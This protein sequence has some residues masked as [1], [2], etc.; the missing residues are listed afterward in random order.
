MI[1]LFQAQ[2]LSLKKI[3]FNKGK[4]LFV[5]VPISLMFGI[6]VLA[7]SEALHKRSRVK[8]R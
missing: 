8:M 7:A 5:I 1:N 3:G 2:K 4:S 6:I